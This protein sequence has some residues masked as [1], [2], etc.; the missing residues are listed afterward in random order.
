MIETEGNILDSAESAWDHDGESWIPADM[1][2]V[3]P[4]YSRSQ[5]DSAGKTLV[6]RGTDMEQSL[7]DVIGNWR[8]AHSF[9]ILSNV[10]VGR[11]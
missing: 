3:S 6:E 8:S 2:W 4:Q 10:G 5:V 7:L 9:E 1:K 11:G